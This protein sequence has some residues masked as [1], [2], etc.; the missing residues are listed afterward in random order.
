M[1]TLWKY[2]LIAIVLI[3][4]LYNLDELTWFLGLSAICG[5][6]VLSESSFWKFLLVGVV[7]STSILILDGPPEV[8]SSTLSSIIGIGKPLVFLAVVIVTSLS[9]AFP[10]WMANLFAF[11]ERLKQS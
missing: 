11:D 1:N 2:A 7:G 8:I 6:L 5:L 3:V 9:F 4:G 10:A